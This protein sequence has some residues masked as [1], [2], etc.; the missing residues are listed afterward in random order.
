[1]TEDVILPQKSGKNIL[2][3]TFFLLLPLRK[4][5]TENRRPFYLHYLGKGSGNLRFPEWNP[6][7]ETALFAEE[8][9]AFLACDGTH[10]FILLP[11]NSKS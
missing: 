3:I 6:Q 4:R 2:I 10:L 5:T 9:S 11:F 1:M 8:N 7:A